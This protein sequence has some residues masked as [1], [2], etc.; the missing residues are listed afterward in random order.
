MHHTYLNLDVNAV[1]STRTTIRL[2]VLVTSVNVF[3][4]QLSPTLL[5][6]QMF[7]IFGSGFSCI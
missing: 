2:N 5:E 3:K 1:T 7:C 4:K 6:L